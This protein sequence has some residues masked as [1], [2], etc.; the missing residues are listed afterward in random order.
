LPHRRVVFCRQRAYAH[1]PPLRRRPS[2][3]AQ[4]AQLALITC[5]GD[6]D[7]GYQA[8]ADNL[9]ALAARP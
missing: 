1:F 7:L 3:N 2:D 5:G 9:E 6:F 4:G 8:S